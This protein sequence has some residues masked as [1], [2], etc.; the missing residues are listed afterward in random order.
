MILK[1]LNNL[2]AIRAVKSHQNK[3]ALDKVLSLSSK[4]ASGVSK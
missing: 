4:I 1:R 2:K 3:L